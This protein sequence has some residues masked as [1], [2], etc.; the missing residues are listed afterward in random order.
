MLAGSGLELTDLI[1]EGISASVSE[2]GSTF[3]ENAILKAVGYRE[4][5]GLPALADDSGLAVDAL[6]GRPGVRSARYAGDEATDLD[7]LELL[8]SE[9]RDVP[10]GKR[11]ARFLCVVAVA[12]PDRQIETF[13]GA[14]EG[15][16]TTAPVG[17]GGFGYDS[18]FAVAE[19]GPNAAVRTMAQLSPEEKAEVSHRGM[20]MGKAAAW[21]QEAARP[22][23][24]SI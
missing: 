20:A 10:C 11:T 22:I 1:T 17:H 14:V 21:L 16:I 23:D 15:F 12:L 19:G 2:T 24:G 6:G 5:S 9:M 13:S 7:N 8:L 4:I 3:S 18:I